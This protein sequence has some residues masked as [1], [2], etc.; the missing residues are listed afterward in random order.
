MPVH[1]GV[2]ISAAAEVAQAGRDAAEQAI[3]QLAG[4][5]PDLWLVF[6]AMRFADPRVLKAIRS[7]SLGTPLVGCTSAGGMITS[8]PQRNALV[9]VGLVGEGVRFLTGVSKVVH[10]DS[11]KA[12]EEL[13]H[14]LEKFRPV[15][16]RALLVFPDGLANNNADV[17]RGL[18]K[19]FDDSLPIG[20]GCAADDFHFQRTFQFFDDEVLTQSVPGVLISGEVRVGFG[21]RHGWLPVGRPRRITQATGSVIH[22]LDRKPA[23]S[24]YEDFL[25]VTPAELKEE[26]IARMAIT[27]PLGTPPE[28]RGE[29]LLRGVMRVGKA[30]SLVCSGDLKPGRTVQLMIGGYQAALEAAQQAARDAMRM[31]G[32]VKLQGALVFS[33]VAR[34]KMLGSESQGEI[35]VIRNALGGAGVRLGGFYTYGE[36]AGKMFHNE[37]VVVITMGS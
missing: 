16:P 4:R 20:G 19:V 31:V 1:M 17:L 29:Y 27:Y 25:G 2:G 21:V 26:S 13:A 6:G 34:Q 22:T 24:I 9:V 32:R 8:G 15:N 33:S 11:Q 12:G 18:R 28:G 23:I 14:T 37:S 5:R 3:A 10:G 30:G 35:D 7:L 36:Y